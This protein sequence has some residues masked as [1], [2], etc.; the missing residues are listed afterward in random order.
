MHYL[1]HTYGRRLRA[2]G[3]RFEDI[4]DLLGH[5]SSSVTVH[6]TAAE[7]KNLITAAEKICD[8]KSSPTISLVKRRVA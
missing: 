5:K 3:V 2:N 4:Q 1:R 8:Q 6:Y 7:I